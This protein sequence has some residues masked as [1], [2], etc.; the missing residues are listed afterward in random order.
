MREKPQSLKCDK[1]VSAGASVNTGAGV[2]AHGGR[3][4]PQTGCTP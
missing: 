3:E 2:S 4:I 1:S